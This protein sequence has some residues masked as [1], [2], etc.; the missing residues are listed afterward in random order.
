MSENE[1][2][3][4]T[5]EKLFG[6]DIRPITEAYETAVREADRVCDAAILLLNKRL[7]SAMKAV[8]ELFQI[9]KQPYHSPVRRQANSVKDLLQALTERE[10]EDKKSAVSAV[11]NSAVQAAKDARDQGLV[12]MEM[13]DFTKF[14]TSHIANRYGNSYA[15]KFLNALPLSFEGL[16]QLANDEGW[17]SDFEDAMQDAVAQGA[18][19]D[20]TVEI[21]RDYT[22][23][24][25]PEEYG[26]KNGEHWVKIVTIPAFVRDTDTRGRLRP[27]ASLDYRITGEARFEKVSEPLNN[28]DPQF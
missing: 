26:A 23:H 20:D 15:Q 24:D 1:K 19:P 2:T 25:V 12:D 21:R 13:D 22:W 6:T 10:H 7:D 17:C 18:L 5:A 14:I 27:I 28:E 16:K 11:R 8:D 3:N 4:E 9:D